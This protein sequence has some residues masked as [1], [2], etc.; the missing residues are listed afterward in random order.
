M[1][2]SVG[3]ITASCSLSGVATSG[4]EYESRIQG[5]IL[6]DGVNSIIATL[7]TGNPTTT[8]SEN[9]GTWVGTTSAGGAGRAGEVLRQRRGLGPHGWGRAWPRGSFRGW[10]LTDAPT[11]WCWSVFLMSGMR[12]RLVRPPPMDPHTGV[13]AI[14][15]CANRTAGYW[16]C[17]WLVLSGVLGK[18]GGVFVAIPDA[19]IGALGAGA[20]RGARCRRLLGA[21]PPTAARGRRRWGGATWG[22]G[23]GEGA[24]T[25]NGWVAGGRAAGSGRTVVCR[26][27]RGMR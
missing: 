4:P 16:A 21:G 17:F 20:R 25:S 18:V 12:C 2:E 3:D 24:T 26:R 23:P 5:G 9:N 1:V 7:M 8:F 10:F 13:I 15:R 22:I 19:V 11:R 27:R 14:T 6:A